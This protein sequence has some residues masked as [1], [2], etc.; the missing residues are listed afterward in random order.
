MSWDEQKLVR[1][2]KD[3]LQ[4]NTFAGRSLF[5]A[6]A[7]N[8]PAGLDTTTVRSATGSLFARHMQS[9]FNLRST[10]LTTKPQ[11]PHK[12]VLFSGELPTPEKI[13]PP[14][15]TPFRFAWKY[16][17]DYDHGGLPLPADYDGLR[18]VFN[19]YS[20]YFPFPE[21]FQPTWTADTLIATHYKVISRQL[22]YKVS[23][24][25]D[26]INHIGY[27]LMGSRQLDRAAY[28]F[29]LNIE[30]YP[31]SFNVYD[32][33]GDLLSA[34]GEKDTAIKCYQQALLLRDED[35]TRQKMEKLRR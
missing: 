22:G 32:S 2:S 16:Y 13:P 18:F 26:L 15:S 21:L 5:L 10:I 11:A 23:P 24:P 17:P 20:I 29:Q 34:R 14:G 3:I 33:M 8:L 30:N 27:Q 7:N 28:Y 9:I 25:E 35:G 19:Y 4:Q 31:K 1:E 6:I 12:F